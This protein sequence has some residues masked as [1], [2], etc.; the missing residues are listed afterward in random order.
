MKKPAF[1]NGRQKI[2]FYK[3][4]QSDLNKNNSRLLHLTFP[5]TFTLLTPSRYF[6]PPKYGIT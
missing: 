1:N 5:P 6:L 2:Y 4:I 3:N